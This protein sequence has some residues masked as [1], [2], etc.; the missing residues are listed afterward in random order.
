MEVLTQPLA[1]PYPMCVCVSPEMLEN[2]GP[3]QAASHRLRSTYL[4]KCIHLIISA[5]AFPT[6]GYFCALSSVLYNLF[7]MS[8]ILSAFMD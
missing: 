7:I 6:V 3:G 8:L 5:Q 1:K 2:A 4:Y